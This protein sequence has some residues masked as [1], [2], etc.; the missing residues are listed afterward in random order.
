LLGVIFAMFLPLNLAQ[1]QP[2][3]VTYEDPQGRFTIQHPSDWAPYPAENR[4]EDIVVEFLKDDTSVG[5][6]LDFDVRIIPNID[7]EV[8][9][10][11]GLEN[12]VQ[13]ATSS[14]Q[15]SIPNFSLEE[16][17]ECETYTL[18][19]NQACSI[20]F[21]RT[22]D[23]MSDQ[24]FAVMQLYTV[25]GNNGWMLTYMATPN[26]FDEFLPVANQ[27]TDSFQILD[28][29]SETTNDTEGVV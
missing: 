19:G 21:T 25:K 27:M 4:F 28:S 7:E 10:E 20:L 13:E 11:F 2:G 22:L 29:S 26:D 18:S 6:L 14:N 17:V 8:V 9:D 3:F 16:E 1:A 24:E 12:F 23:Y 15:Y 5:R